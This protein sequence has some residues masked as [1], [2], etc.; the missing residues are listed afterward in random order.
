MEINCK[1]CTTSNCVNT[2]FNKNELTEFA[3]FQAPS[4]L[5]LRQDKGFHTF[6]YEAERK[7]IS[8]LDNKQ[9]DMWYYFKRFKSDVKN[10]VNFSRDKWSIKR[11]IRCR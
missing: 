5:L 2:L 4:I 6:G 3:S 8:L 1:S 7:Y 11:M 9:Q 10:K